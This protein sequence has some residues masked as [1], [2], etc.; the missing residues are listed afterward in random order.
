MMLPVM[1]NSRGC[2]RAGFFFRLEVMFKISSN[3]AESQKEI[4]SFFKRETPPA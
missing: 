1:L 4:S 3:G 2:G